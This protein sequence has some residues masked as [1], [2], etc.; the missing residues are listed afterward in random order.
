MVVQPCLCQ[1]VILRLETSKAGFSLNTSDHFVLPGLEGEIEGDSLL[2]GAVAMALCCI[3]L[4]L[5]VD[6]K[7]LT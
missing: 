5:G 1:M 3:L 6:Y 2:A 4:L 7:N